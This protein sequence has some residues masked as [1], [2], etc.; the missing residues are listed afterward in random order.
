MPMGLTNAPATHQARLE[1]AL[2]DLIN[3]Y[4]VVYLD[5]IVIFLDSFEQHEIHLRRVL[6]QLRAANLYCSPKKTQL[7]RHKVKFLG[8]WITAEGFQADNE[9]ITK[10][11]DW[12]SPRSPKGV[13]KFLGTVQWMKKFIWGLQKYVGTLTPLT[14]TKLDKKDFKWGDREEAAFQNIKRIMTSLPCLKNI[15]YESEDPLWLFTDASGSGLGAALF[16]G[17]EW[18]SASPIAY[19]SHLMTPA[20]KNYPVH[21]QELLAVIHALQKW[22]MLLLGMKVNVM[23]DHHSLTYLL[24]QRNLSRQQA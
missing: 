19:E 15:D 5:D 21:E 14:S 20:E 11:R 2:G 7:F 8:H 1:E 12:P 16:Q 17:K 10:V 22:R 6:E 23:T 24:K 18:K 13:K 3:N 9:K 4:C